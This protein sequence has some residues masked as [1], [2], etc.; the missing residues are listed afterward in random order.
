[1]VYIF[2]EPFCKQKPSE[3]ILPF[4]TDSASAQREADSFRAQPNFLQQST[5]NE[6]PFWFP[7]FQR[8]KE[9]Y[10]VFSLKKPDKTI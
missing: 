5:E 8:G 3:G 7:L 9:F 1:M 2:F 4:G 10:P 6:S